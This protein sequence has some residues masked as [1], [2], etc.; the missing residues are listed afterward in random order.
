M[1]S[2]FYK[3]AY[4]VFMFLFSPFMKTRIAKVH[5]RID[6][7]LVRNELPILFVA[8]H[9]SWWDG[10]LLLR[11]HNKI[12][13][14]K[15]YYTIMLERE[16]RRYPFFRL[17]GCIGLTPGSTQS[18]RTLLANISELRKKKNDFSVCFYPQGR[19]WPF[20][21][22]P[23]GFHK[24]IEQIAKTLLPIQIIPVALRFE[25]LNSCAP[26]AFVYADNP[27]LLETV[28]DCSNL[29]PRLEQIIMDSL[30]SI[31]LYLE[32]KGEMAVT[33]EGI[34]AHL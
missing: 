3:P 34:G 29:A 32:E 6:K 33:D 19:I 25:P 20:H 12:R 30:L 26:H 10:F 1:K 2:V 8:N 22:K 28:E 15:D 11:L 27:L 4:A 16:L 21:K 31:S 23:L 14:H 7:N 17:L 18:L 5:I 13:P 9:T 24:G